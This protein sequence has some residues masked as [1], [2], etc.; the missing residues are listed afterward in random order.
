[1]INIRLLNEHDAIAY[2]EKRI[3]ALQIHPEVFSSSVEE[4]LDYSL[5][6]HASRLR[7]SNAYTFGA[8]EKDKLVGVVTL[9]IEMKRKLMHRSDIFAMYVTPEVRRLGVGKQLM[10]AAIAQAK[11][12]DEVE[13]VYLTV[14]TNNTAAKKLYE[15]VGFE[16]IGSDP[17]S[18]KIGNK[19]IGE[20]MMALY[21]K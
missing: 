16:I 5:E 19:Y 21:L 9:V 7:A 2:K 20:E 6:V 10:E 1:M 12:L 15:S 13:Q 8:F 17:R 14:S 11:E 4:E 18:M 3:E